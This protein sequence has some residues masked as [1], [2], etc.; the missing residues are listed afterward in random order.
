MWGDQPFS[1]N[2]VYGNSDI[3]GAGNWFE[4]GNIAMDHVHLWYA[5]CCTGGLEADWDIAVM[6]AASDGTITAKMHADTFAILEGSKNPEAAF[7][8]M[9]F[10][11]GDAADELTQLYGGLPARLS[12]QGQYFDTLDASAFADKD[13]TWDV[14]IASMSYP[15]NPNHEEGYPNELQARDAL[16]AFDE[17]LN[18]NPDF[19]VAAGLE[20][21]QQAL[22]DI[23]DGN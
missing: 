11:I 16:A 8:V 7:D 6:P 22:Q 17:Q 21:L 20:E 13:I 10:L 15:D 14:V 1:P 4:S 18:N 23:F 5:T 12:L 2:A 9:Q 19:D 3:L